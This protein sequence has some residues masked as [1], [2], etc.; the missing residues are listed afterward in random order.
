MVLPTA[1]ARLVSPAGSALSLMPDLLRTAT[2]TVNLA[3]VAAAADEY[4]SPAASA[5]EKPGRP[6]SRLR[7]IAAWT[8]SAT[9][10]IMPRHVCSAP[11]G[12]RRRTRAWQF[13]SAPCL[14]IGRLSSHH[15]ALD[16]RR[17]AP[18]PS[19]RRRQAC[20]Y[21]DNASAL[22]TYPQAQQTTVSTKVDCFE[23]GPRRP[24]PSPAGDYQLKT[25][26]RLTRPTAPSLRGSR[27]PFTRRNESSRGHETD[28]ALVF[29]YNIERWT[30]LAPLPKLA[31]DR[32]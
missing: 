13:R 19:V 2:C 17:S 32:M 15:C 16:I 4:L 11:C 30:S 5:Q 12:A 24:C 8:P 20:G 10:G 28:P 31:H 14:P 25:S 26:G 29:I 21:V 1:A 18:R 23:G 3:A 9:G 22:P 7:R 27:Q 6:F